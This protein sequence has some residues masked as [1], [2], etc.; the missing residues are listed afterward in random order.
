MKFTSIFYT[1]SEGYIH[2]KGVNYQQAS[3]KYEVYFYI[4]HSERRI[5]SRQ[6]RKLP[7]SERKTQNLF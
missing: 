3:G 6:R 2:A 5:Y 1:A 7:T 4:L